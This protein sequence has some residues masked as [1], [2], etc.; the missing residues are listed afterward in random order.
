MINKRLEAALKYAGR[1]WQV[2]PCKLNKTPHVKWKTGATTDKAIIKDWW[3]KWPNAGIGIV[4]G[5]DSGLL[6]VDVD[7]KSGGLKT[8]KE[9]KGKHGIFKTSKVCTG[10][11]GLHLYFEYPSIGARNSAGLIAQGIDVRADGGYVIV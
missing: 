1:G 5:K 9:W 7:K 6:V 10:G 2:F 11:G 4:C 3:T 8:Y